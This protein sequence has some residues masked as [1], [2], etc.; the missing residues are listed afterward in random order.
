LRIEQAIPSSNDSCGAAIFTVE[1][2]IKGDGSKSQWYI[3]VA[4]LRVGLA[5]RITPYTV[6]IIITLKIIIISVR[7]KGQ[8]YQNHRSSWRL[9]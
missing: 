5:N 9:V 6:I 4:A 2:N 7:V 3:R 1:M 8:K